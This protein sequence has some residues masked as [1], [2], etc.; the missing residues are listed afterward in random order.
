MEK[1]RSIQDKHKL[2]EFTTLNLELQKINVI[3]K[4]NNT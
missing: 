3:Y 1:T 4:E 2:R